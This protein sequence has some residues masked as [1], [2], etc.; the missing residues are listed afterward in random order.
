MTRFMEIFLSFGFANRPNRILFHV[1]LERR[2][3]CAEF[4]YFSDTRWKKWICNDIDDMLCFLNKDLFFCGEEVSSGIGKIF[5]SMCFLGSYNEQDL[6]QRYGR[7]RGEFGAL[8]AVWNA[9]N[10]LEIVCGTHSRAQ[11]LIDKSVPVTT[12]LNG[13]V[14]QTLVSVWKYSC[15]RF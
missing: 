3:L 1:I 4:Y 10:L 12:L 15:R 7:H 8:F 14:L 11:Y 13:L 9:F 2:E 6:E 5:S